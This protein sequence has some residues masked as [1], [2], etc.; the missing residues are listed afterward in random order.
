MIHI[1]TRNLEFLLYDL[2][3]LLASGEISKAEYMTIGLQMKILQTLTEMSQ[4]DG[5][6]YKSIS[7]DDFKKPV[8]GQR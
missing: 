1:K 4:R 7:L 3:R 6:H 8:D 2:D 5:D